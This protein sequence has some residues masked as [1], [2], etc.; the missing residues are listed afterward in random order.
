M[1]YKDLNKIS[2]FHKVLTYS[3]DVYNFEFIEKLSCFLRSNM[4]VGVKGPYGCGKTYMLFN[5]A[6]PLLESMYKNKNFELVTFYLMNLKSAKDSWCRPV[7]KNDNSVFEMTPNLKRVV[8]IIKEGKIPV[9]LFEE[10]NRLDVEGQNILLPLLEIKKGGI[11]ELFIEQTGDTIQLPP[12]TKILLTGNLSG[13]SGT[14][15]NDAVESRINSLGLSR[16]DAKK[17]R[18]T[19]LMHSDQNENIATLNDL[20]FVDRAL[21]K[22][23]EIQVEDHLWW[24]DE[25]VERKAR[26]DLR[27]IEKLKNNL[28]HAKSIKKG[29]QYIIESLSETIDDT[30]SDSIHFIRSLKNKLLLTFQLSTV[31]YYNF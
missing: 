17:L 6:V 21:T 31:E 26:M 11:H 27:E 23:E 9:I 14:S 7:I 19:I 12:E 30:D 5:L 18:N 15:K 8:K 25:H 3:D 29:V 22:E 13:S 2:T 28:Y 24:F 4:P 1:A 16:A 20:E 10:Y